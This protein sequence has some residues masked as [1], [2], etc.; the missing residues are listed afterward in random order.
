M[1]E[2]I[3]NDIYHASL[4]NDVLKLSENLTSYLDKPISG[5]RFRHLEFKA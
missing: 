4:E 3:V 1:V 5:E 2:F